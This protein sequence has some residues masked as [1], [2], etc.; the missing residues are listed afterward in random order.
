MKHSPAAIRCASSS[1]DGGLYPYCIARPRGVV[2]IRDSRARRPTRS[3]SRRPGGS[4]IRFAL[5]L[6]RSSRVGRRSG[7]QRHARATSHPCGPDGRSRSKRLNHTRHPPNALPAH[8]RCVASTGL[9]DPVRNAVSLGGD[10]DTLAAIAGAVGERCTDCPKRSCSPP[11]NATCRAPKTSR[12]RSMRS[13]SVPGTRPRPPSTRVYGKSTT[14]ETATEV[15]EPQGRA[16]RTRH[17]QRSASMRIGAQRRVSVPARARARGTQCQR[18]RGVR[19]RAS[20]TRL[21]WRDASG[22]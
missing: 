8:L 2:P 12:Q 22:V 9:E 7:T 11:E 16:R 17:V 18:R 14:S 10:A 5:N 21:P 19:A 15:R 13:T 6:S 1:T 20:R 3:G 4:S